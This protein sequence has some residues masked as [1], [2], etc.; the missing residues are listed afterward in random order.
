MNVDT[1]LYVLAAISFA[2]GGF[3]IPPFGQFDWLQVGAFFLT[4]SLIL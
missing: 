1:L 2:I 3:R 4:L